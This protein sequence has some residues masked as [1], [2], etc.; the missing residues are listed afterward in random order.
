MNQLLSETF[1]ELFLSVGTQY[2]SEARFSAWKVHVVSLRCVHLLLAGFMCTKANVI[3]IKLL[4]WT[5]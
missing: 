5:L 4:A 3:R 1:R 2:S